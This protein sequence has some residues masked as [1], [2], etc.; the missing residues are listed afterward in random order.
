MARY[1]VKY[2]EDF[3][4]TF[5]PCHSVSTA[6]RMDDIH[7]LVRSLVTLHLCWGASVLSRSKTIAFFAIVQSALSTF[8]SGTEL[9]TFILSCSQGAA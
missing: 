6:F 3:T 8:V 2:R 1:L 5:I 7:K 9:Q 4:F